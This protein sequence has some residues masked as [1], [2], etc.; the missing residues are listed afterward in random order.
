M[1]F[2]RFSERRI[3]VNI[4]STSQFTICTTTEEKNKILD[5]DSFKNNLKN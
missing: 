2:R 3:D 1:I 4:I 5:D